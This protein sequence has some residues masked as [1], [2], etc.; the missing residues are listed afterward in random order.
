MTARE[1]VHRPGESW[2]VPA[3]PGL[4]GPNSLI[5]VGF[6]LPPP[7]HGLPRLP[8]V[9]PFGFLRLRTPS[10]EGVLR[11]A[12]AGDRGSLIDEPGQLPKPI[13]PGVGQGV[14]GP[15]TLAIGEE[16]EGGAGGTWIAAPGSEQDRTWLPSARLRLRS[17]RERTKIVGAGS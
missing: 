8:Y 10:R 12:P 9:F 13:Y 3:E 15:E 14:P 11:R 6:L 16:E 4:R 17:S 1:G 2:Y 7:S 5:R